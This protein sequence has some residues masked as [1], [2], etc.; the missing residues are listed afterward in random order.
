[1]KIVKKKNLI[2]TIMLKIMFYIFGKRR[3]I[4]YKIFME[5]TIHKTYVQ[6]D[7]ERRQFIIYLFFWGGG[8]N[9]G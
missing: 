8:N 6:V 3:K 2:F 5:R 4:F 7:N 9:K 1:M